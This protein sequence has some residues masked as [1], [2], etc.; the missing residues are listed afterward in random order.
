MSPYKN[1]LVQHS[2]T[3]CFFF[4]VF[5]NKQWTFTNT[6][7]LTMKLW[8]NGG[9]AASGKLMTLK[10]SI[11]AF[12]SMTLG[13]MS[14]QTLCGETLCYMVSRDKTCERPLASFLF[15]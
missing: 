9:R 13:M 3:S 8:M 5:S 11:R 6:E 4:F 1:A 14:S 15:C 7:S 2:I 12:F 10:V